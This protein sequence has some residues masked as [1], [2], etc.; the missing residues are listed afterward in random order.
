[1]SR[2]NL[3]SPSESPQTSVALSMYPTMVTGLSFGSAS[4]NLEDRLRRL[5]KITGALMRIEVVLCK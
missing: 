2:D 5:C 4:C 3:E 1:M